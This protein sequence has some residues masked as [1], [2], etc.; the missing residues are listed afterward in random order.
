MVVWGDVECKT[1]IIKVDWFGF[2]PVPQTTP[3]LN[4]KKDFPEIKKMYI[5]SNRCD[6]QF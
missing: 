1:Y 2:G 5:F 3:R 6:T 4:Y